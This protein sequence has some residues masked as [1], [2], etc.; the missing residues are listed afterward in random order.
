MLYLFAGIARDGDIRSHLQK[1]CAS[2]QLVLTMHE[3]DLV[4]GPDQDLTSTVLWDNLFK[5]IQ[6]GVFDVL[7]LSPPCS[8]FSRAR[9]RYSGTFGPRPLRSHAHLLGFPWLRDADN[10]R[11][12]QANFFV[13][14]SFKAARLQQQQGL[15]FILEHPEDLGRVSSGERPASIWA[16]DEILEMCAGGD[17]ACWGVHQCFFGAATSKPTRLLSNLPAALRFG[18]SL[19]VFDDDGRYL[20]PLQKCPHAHDQSACGY[21]DGAWRSTAAAAYPSEFSEFLA[22]L[23]FSSVHEI[24]AVAGSD[25]VPAGLPS[26]AEAFAAECLTTGTFDR[27]AVQLLF[28]LLP[29]TRPHR[30]TGSAEPGTAFFGGTVHQDGV[31]VPRTSCFEYPDSMRVINA[32]LHSVDPVHRYAAFVLTKNVTSRVH[33]DPRNGAANNMVVRISDFAEGGLWIQDPKGTVFREYHGS[34]VPGQVHSLQS[35]PVYLDA[36]SFLHATESW[37]GDRLIAIAYTPQQMHLLSLDDSAFLQS[38]G[39]PVR[40]SFPAGGEATAESPDVTMDA[41]QGPGPPEAFDSGTGRVLPIDN[42]SEGPPEAFDSRTGRVLPID[43]VSEGPP[44]ALDSRTGRVL[45]IDNA[46]E[47]PPEAFDPRTSRSFGQPMI[48]R[49]QMCKQEFVDGFGLCSPG[50]W[51]P[52]SREKLAAGNEIAHAE[53]VRGLLREFVTCQL[54]DPKGMAFRLAT[55][56]LKESPFS[57][58]AL[59][60]LRQKIVSAIPGG[61]TDLLRVPERQPFYLYLLAE[62]LRILGDPDWEIL[63]QGTECYAEGMP[64]GYDSPLP[65]APQVFRP[66]DRFRKLDESE[67]EPQMQNYSSAEMSADKI[68]EHFRSEEQEGLMIATTE[69]AVKAEYGAGRLLVAAMGAI[70]KPSGDVRPLHDATHGVRLNNNIV[71]GDRLEVP[72]PAEI[73]ETVSQA[74]RDRGVPFSI[75]A[76]ISKAHRRAKVRRCDWP[77]LGCRSTSTSKV[78][79]LNCVGTFGVSSAAILWARLFGCVGRW[80]LR[81]MG[82]LWNIQIVYVDDLHIVVVGPDKY[83]VLWMI[84]AAY[85]LLGT[86]FSYKK[87]HGGVECEFVGY[88]LSYRESAAGISSKRTR[89]V[90]DWIDSA[91]ANNWYVTGRRF[92]EFLGRLNFV[93]RVLTWVKPFL[94]PLY[95]F[96][97]VLQKGTVARIPELVFVALHYIREQLAESRGLHSVLQDWRAPREAFRT[98]AKCECNLVVLGGYSL[99]CGMSPWDARWFCLDVK[100]DDLP[101][102]FKETGDSQWASTSAELLASLAALKAF[103]HLEG[104]ITGV[105]D[106]F[107]TS[108]CGGTDNS[109]TAKLQKKGSSTKWPLMGIQMAC[110]AAL[111]KVNKQLVLQWRPRD[112]NT[113]SDAITN[114]DFSNFCPERRVHIKLDD[115]PLDIFLRMV[116]SRDSF[117]N[118]RVSL[119]RLVS[120]EAAM[121]RREKAESRTEW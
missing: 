107:R 91:E 90:T 101:C 67:F 21:T 5:M 33:R 20:G 37:A 18:V 55:G 96:D 14:Q 76:D 77:L 69:G 12:E 71:I 35:G 115:L 2:Q 49:F 120:K 111:R 81:V 119:Q 50:R 99:E 94:A 1:I 79:W 85:E 102:L 3:F 73:V 6:I 109:S 93:S 53:K 66:R 29:K 36:R 42:A 110:A 89:W 22:R 25:R 38:L 121:S 8:T 7:I 60:G 17:I 83:V 9:H 30:I 19:P 82:R 80:V 26:S 65:R 46:S 78:V 84:L 75:S 113:L 105:H 62:S 106:C 39:F 118:A 72:G 117:L 47:G 61:S 51:A 24:Q 28:E 98:D 45:P 92:A 15:Y 88:W 27:A 56:H 31:T 103:N 100:P 10:R 34:W 95:A 44:E 54:K 59:Q 52:E 4:R 116:H 23:C 64:V 97:A 40:D 108:V 68:E 43:N 114:H 13:R 87:F 63:V 112:E 104:E 70:L 11:V 57:G 48:C 41:S 16:F 74:R 32:F 58:E 86:P